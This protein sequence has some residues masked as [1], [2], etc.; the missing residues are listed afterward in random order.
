MNYE[1]N[2]NKF[3]V[4]SNP[5]FLSEGKKKKKKIIYNYLKKKIKEML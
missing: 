3:I 2:K 5:E 1:T 4:L